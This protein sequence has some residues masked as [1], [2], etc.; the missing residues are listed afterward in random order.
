[1]NKEPGLRDLA[2]EFYRKEWII[3]Y[4]VAKHINKDTGSHECECVYCIW[5][6]ELKTFPFGR[7]SDTVMAN[8]FA[9][10][11][12]KGISSQVNVSETIDIYEESASEFNNYEFY[13][14]G[15]LYD[16]SYDEDKKPFNIG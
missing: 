11:P 15:L 2:A 7:N 14:D 8:W 4:D 12:L 16:E 3:P 1:M 9:S 6:D 13:I 10:I 5:L